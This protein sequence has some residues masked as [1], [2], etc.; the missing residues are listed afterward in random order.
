MARRHR[1]EEQELPFVAL[2]DTMTNVVGVLT[3]VLVMMGISLAR[4]ASRVISSLPPATR[5][6]V[7][8]ALKDLDRIK[9][10]QSPLDQRLALLAKSPP[11]AAQL[12]ALDSEAAKLERAAGPT[13]AA[14]DLKALEAELSRRE[15]ELNQ[16]KSAMSLLLE[17]QGKL[18]AS[19]DASP[20]Q[21]VQAPPAKVVRIPVA[22]PI[23]QDADIELVLVTKESVHRLDPESAKA[24]VLREFKQATIRS[25]LAREEK[26]GGKTVPIYDH[27][28]LAKYF[29]NRRLVEREFKIALTF[30]GWTS[31]PV[32][33]VSPRQASPAPPR[34][35]LAQIK[36]KPKAVAMFRVT[37][38]GYENYLAAREV[39]DKIGLPAGWEASGPEHKIHLPEIETN[40]PKDPPRPAPPPPP[41]GAAPPVQIKP[42]AKTLD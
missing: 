20:V 15:A 22:R 30:E 28:K 23:P 2:M 11:T 25:T 42:P 21:V 6:Q 38:D 24:V 41:P 8:L 34:L 40:R 7:D 3:I 16:Q 9:A 26:R 14:I 1:H 4:A 13:G 19:L 17:E 32:L 10:M 27:Q 31:S 36:S 37:S 39:C 35:V 18:K 33:V 12:A 29:E 5:E